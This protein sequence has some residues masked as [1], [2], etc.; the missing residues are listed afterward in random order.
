MDRES[1]R[2]PESVLGVGHFRDIS[3]A[4]EPVQVKAVVPELAVELFT[5][6]FCVGLAES[7]AALTPDYL[8][9]DRITGMGGR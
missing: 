7:G 3:K 8:K 4:R 1:D 2:T 5:K 6:A 9:T